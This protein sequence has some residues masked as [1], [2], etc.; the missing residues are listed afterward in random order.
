MNSVRVPRC[1]YSRLWSIGELLIK[2]EPLRF[3]TTIGKVSLFITLSNHHTLASSLSS[4]GQGTKYLL[5]VLVLSLIS[6]R[7]YRET[8]YEFHSSHRG[9][10][11]ECRSKMVQMGVLA[12]FAHGCSGIPCRLEGRGKRRLVCWEAPLWLVAE[13]A[14]FPSPTRAR[15]HT[16]PSRQHRSAR[17]RADMETF[18]LCCKL[19]R[20]EVV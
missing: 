9:D 3:S 7:V 18:K 16:Q 13:H 12:H 19:K 11:P 17:R 1:H 10:V 15:S 14:S 5:L 2:R 20:R 8:L 4:N 6:F